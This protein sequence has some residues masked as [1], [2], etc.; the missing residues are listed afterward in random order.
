[1]ASRWTLKESCR[2]NSIFVYRIITCLQ[3]LAKK[4]SINGWMPSPLFRPSLSPSSTLRGN[5][6]FAF[7]KM[8]NRNESSERS[9]AFNML[10]LK[11]TW[12]TWSCKGNLSLSFHVLLRPLPWAKNY[13]PGNFQF[14]FDLI[15]HIKR[16]KWKIN[17]S[18]FQTSFNY[19]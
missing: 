4:I 10:Q 2:K 5:S 16:R 12:L 1:M 8:K 18:E 15:S 7:E 17:A 13:K 9:A 6:A 14:K 3:N 11:W 19:R